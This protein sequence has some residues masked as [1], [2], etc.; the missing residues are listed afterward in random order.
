MATSVV[1]AMA[2]LVCVAVAAQFFSGPAPRDR[3]TAAA[4][5]ASTDPPTTPSPS[6]SRSARK[7]H[8]KRHPAATAAS[9]SGV[10]GGALFGGD[11]HLAG[12]AG[13]LGRKLAIVRVYFRL[14][15]RFPRSNDRHL[16]A[17]GSTLLVS[18]DTLPGGPTYADIA[19]GR[20][21]RTIRA[22]LL[23]V[24]QAAVR[25][26]LGAIYVCFEHEANVPGT[27]HGLGTPAQFVAAWDHVH[28]LAE[29]AG[30]DWN[31][32]GRLHWVWILTHYAFQQRVAASYWPGGN[33][34]DV[35]GADGYNTGGCR[36]GQAAGSVGRTPVV[37]PAALFDSA[38]AFARAQGLP[39][40]VAEWGSVRYASA[41]VREDFIRQMAVYVTANPQIEAA[42]YWDWRVPPCNYMVN[43]DPLSLSALAA[44][45]QSPS[46]QG[47]VPPPS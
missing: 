35:I 4:S 15:E 5:A 1:V 36:T 41:S 14:G 26:G 27:R 20:Q 23:A 9:R 28:Q 33:E 29:N 25:Y 31:Q 6:P 7:H 13:A 46:L 22:F 45:A 44:M 39:I 18:L 3:P 40:F 2:V 12:E 21:D 8:H 47:R 37:G 24:D 19:A 11:V 43:Y 32:G 34:V 16:M 30:L 10:V 42:L 38:V 17:E